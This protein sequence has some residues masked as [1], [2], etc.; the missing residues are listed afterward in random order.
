MCTLVAGR[1]RLY[2]SRRS[3]CI[4]ASTCMVTS[5]RSLSTEMAEQGNWRRLAEADKGREL[6]HG[7]DGCVEPFHGEAGCVEPLHGEEWDTAGLG[8]DTLRSVRDRLLDANCDEEGVGGV[9]LLSHFGRELALDAG[10]RRRTPMGVGCIS[11]AIIGVK[12]TVLLDLFDRLNFA[13]KLLVEGA[14]AALPPFQSMYSGARTWAFVS[15]PFSA[16]LDS[17]TFH[18]IHTFSLL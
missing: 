4:S 2:D 9:F 12:G 14:A 18:G 7:E 5:A 10:S 13:A 11:S 16:L 17:L 6:P 8:R 1:E 3:C 15:A